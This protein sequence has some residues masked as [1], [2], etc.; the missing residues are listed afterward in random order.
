MQISDKAVELLRGNHKAMGR[1]CT[2]F[3]KHMKTIENWISH[4]DVRLTTPGALQIL[5]EETKLPDEELLTEKA[6]VA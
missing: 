5:R 1:L 2:M 3:D 4:R 6:E